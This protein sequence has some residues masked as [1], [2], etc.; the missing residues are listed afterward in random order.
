MMY[1][2]SETC[3]L[4]GPI[5][6]FQYA[7]DDGP[8]ILY[9]PWLKDVSET[10][11]LFEEVANHEICGFNLSFDWFHICQMWTT[12]CVLE[13]WGLGKV[14]LEEIINDYAIAEKVGRDGDCLKPKAALDL[15]LHARKGPY[16]TLMN[17]E[18]IRIRKVPTPLA[19]ALA[20]ELNK[21]ISLEAIYFARKKIKSEQ[22]QVFDKEDPEF[23]DI[24]MKFAPSTALKVLAKHALK[25]PDDEIL[26]FSQIEVSKSFWP[27]ELGYAPYALANTDYNHLSVSE[28][29]K[30]KDDIDWK[31]SWPQFINAHVAHWE[32]DTLAREYAAGDVDKTRRLHYHF[33]D[34]GEVC[35]AGDDDSELACMVGA[36]RWHGFAV[37]I[38]GIKKIREDAI[39]K[40][41]GIPT[42]PAAVRRWLADALEPT[43]LVVSEMEEKGSTGKVILEKMVELTS[44]C[45][46][47]SSCDQCQGR[48]E[49][50]H[51]V[52]KRAKA[53]L[54]AREAIKERELYDKLLIADR[55]QPDFNVIGTLTSRMSGTGGLNAHGIKKAKKVRKQFTLAF[56]GYILCGGDFSAFEVVLAIAIWGSKKLE[57]TITSYRACH[58]CSGQGT[59]TKCGKCFGKGRITI[60]DEFD[61]YTL[62]CPLCKEGEVEVEEK[63]YNCKGKGQ[64]KTKIHALFGTF[65]YPG[66]TYEEI[67]ESDGSDDFD[68]YTRAKSG[69]FSQLYGGT[70]YTLATRLGIDLES[71][72]KGF[73]HFLRE[74]PDVANAIRETVQAFQSMKQV[75]KYGKIEWHDPADFVE[76]PILGHRRYFTL[77]NRICKELFNL[78][79]KVPPEWA[80]IKIKVVRRDR[81]QTVS[82]AVQSALYAAAFQ[83]QAGNTRAALNHKIQ[84]AGG[85][86]TKY[87]QRKVWDLQP[88]GPNQFVVL[89]MNVHDEL[90]CPTLPEFVTKVSQV[91][92]DS[93][94]YFKAKVPLL[95]MDWNE[96]IKNWSAKKG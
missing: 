28:L 10:K 51:P 67:L 82:G 45:C 88:S 9:N 25:I 65:M 38:E 96:N 54:N 77:E 24:V 71:A 59:T 80:K 6:L 62:P 48:G 89:P 70:A 2:D 64:V 30:I 79:Q 39:K 41:E 63:C 40:T 1:L 27:K 33:L 72:E 21:R 43:E 56:P 91:I 36:V 18:D 53:V 66:K 14:C 50:V 84:S 32:V 35:I 90:M 46:N 4:T 11:Q 83:I 34:N 87:V 13:Q 58:I 12:C 3:G 75:S 15:M 95:A 73:Q 85:K 20:D 92:K 93:I 8:I 19:F 44:Y 78:A 74:Y 60:E 86:I 69:L 94:N 68:Y 49:I 52:A 76:E 37:N 16:Q 29:R 26:L 17:R 42:S 81:E 7:I 47:R 55:L 57:E 61:D 23:K 5:V 22:W 31:Q